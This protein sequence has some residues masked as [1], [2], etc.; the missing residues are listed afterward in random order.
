MTLAY[1]EKKIETFQTE[2]HSTSVLHLLSS[3]QLRLLWSRKDNFG[4]QMEDRSS[5][6]NSIPLNMDFIINIFIGI[7][8]Y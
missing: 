3:T 8:T 4:I 5:P 1:E 2:L 6:E 7:S